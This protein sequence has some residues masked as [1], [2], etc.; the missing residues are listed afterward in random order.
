M[1]PQNW[2][3]FE[4]ALLLNACIE[5][6]DGKIGKDKAI[7]Q[8]SIALRQMAIN[9]KIEID[10]VYRNTNGIQWQLA[11]MKKALDADKFDTR[12]PP[13]LFSDVAELYRSDR[14]QFNNI[15]LEAKKM[16]KKEEEAMQDNQPSTTKE[17]FKVWYSSASRK[18]P[19]AF[20]IDVYEETFRQ[21]NDK[22]D[23]T[24]IWDF[25]DVKKYNT[26]H[27]EIISKKLFRII[28]R[29]TFTN[30]EKT[31]KFYV[32][33]LKEYESDKKSSATIAQTDTVSA[34]ECD[35]QTRSTDETTFISA[36]E[37]HPILPSDTV[38]DYF[39]DIKLE[40]PSLEFTNIDA[41]GIVQRRC[42]YIFRKDLSRNGH[43]LLEIWMNRGAAFFTI[44]AKRALLTEDENKEIDQTHEGAS[45]TRGKIE[46]KFV[47]AEDLISFVKDKLENAENVDVHD[48]LKR[49]R[50][51]QDPEPQKVPTIDETLKEHI[52][53]LLKS[54]Y[55]YGFRYDSP[56]EQNRLR[57]FAAEENIALPENDDELQNALLACG[58]VIEGKL[59]AKD[60]NMQKALAQLIQNIVDN[61]VSVIYYESLLEKQS[62]FMSDNHI[63]GEE[64]LK[65][66]LQKSLTGFAFGGKYMNVGDRSTEIEL[67]GNEIRRIWGEEAIFHYTDM[68]NRLPYIPEPILQRVLSFNPALVWN[69]EGEYLLLDRFLISEDEKAEIVDFVSSECEKDGFASL[70]EVPMKKLEIEN[71]QVSYVGMQ[72]AIYETVLKESYSLNG[73]IL[74]KRGAQSLDAVT[75]V[76]A[77]LHGKDEVTFDEAL[78]TVKEVIG[79]AQRHIAF[80]ALYDDFVRVDKNRFVA[81][82]HLRF[83][84]D[85]IDAV[86]KDMLP[87]GFGAIKS[88]TTYAMFPM[89]GYMWNA[90]VLESYCYLFSKEYSLHVVNFNDKNAGIVAKKDINKDYAEL[91]AMALAKAVAVTDEMKALDYLCENGYLAKHSYGRIKEVLEKAEEYRGVK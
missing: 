55:A 62:E 13:K 47:Y 10:D 28:H 81:R 4:A 70:L 17:A 71:Y 56:R 85:E 54:H 91:L 51:N 82:Q 41:K 42:V 45:L 44:W 63:S 53:S 61:G 78:N 38:L 12:N 60:E 31:W 90:Y 58:N 76:K 20:V 59:Y 50:K 87:D 37:K 73:K 25:T 35:G 36:V 48:L 16:C 5:I 86:L 3:K 15:L 24:C 80:R 33:F 52:I 89:C 22:K 74:T 49:P 79:D 6:Q 64:M 72:M 84:V 27:N 83:T 65:D 19:L 34:E 69:A 26:R 14:E 11:F 2:D 1:R 8:I 30:F 57:T 32:D 18:Y 75:I 46:R 88:I 68:V 7:S 23:I 66:L 77:A 21:S 9:K 67:V 39:N 29:S 40:I 43:V